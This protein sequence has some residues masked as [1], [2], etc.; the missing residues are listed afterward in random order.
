MAERSLT[1]PEAW[2]AIAENIGAHGLE[3]GLCWEV[4]GALYAGIISGETYWAMGERIR[5]HLE[6]AGRAAYFERPGVGK[7]R[8]LLALFFALEAEDEG[9]A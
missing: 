2:R 1:E 3:L 5:A 6:L 7:N 4:S 8:L 9:A